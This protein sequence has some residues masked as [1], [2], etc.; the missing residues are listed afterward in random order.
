MGAL[1]SLTPPAVAATAAAVR[2][3]TAA[4]TTAAAAVPALALG[5]TVGG[6]WIRHHR[7]SGAQLGDLFIT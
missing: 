1:V 2:C 3:A 6:V 7:N 4:T 5:S